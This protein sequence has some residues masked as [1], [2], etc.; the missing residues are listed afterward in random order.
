M[1]TLFLPVWLATRSGPQLAEGVTVGEFVDKQQT[2]EIWGLGGKYAVDNHLLFSPKSP[3]FALYPQTKSLNL[4]FR[5]Q[6]VDNRGDNFLELNG[7]DFRDRAGHFS[8]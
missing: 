7:H 3:T 4:R 5:P 6:A 8:G 2:Q 1:R